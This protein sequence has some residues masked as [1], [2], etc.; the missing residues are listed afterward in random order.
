MSVRR[1]HRDPPKLQP[2][3][4]AKGRVTLSWSQFISDMQ[5]PGNATDVDVSYD[6][7][8]IPSGGFIKVAVPAQG[9]RPGNFVVA[10]FDQMPN[11]IELTQ[12]ITVA[13]VVVV[14]FEND[15]GAAVDLP[16]GVLRVRFWRHDP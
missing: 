7:I 5:R 13:D 15:S 10:S 6:P 8:N 4:D 11:E 12:K 2:V 9:A 16:P 14:K 3:V 1:Y